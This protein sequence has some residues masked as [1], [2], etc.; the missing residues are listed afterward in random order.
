MMIF[1][2]IGPPFPPAFYRCETFYT[3]NKWTGME[4]TMFY[5]FQFTS[6]LMK[7]QLM[8]PT[9]SEM[10]EHSSYGRY[11]VFVDK[12]YFLGLEGEGLFK[13]YIC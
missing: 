5:I 9:L 11:I 2:F 4:V 1:K 3:L 8:H 6:K 7:I 10:N 12:T 13:C